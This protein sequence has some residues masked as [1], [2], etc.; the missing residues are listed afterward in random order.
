MNSAGQPPEI[1]DRHRRRAF[2]ERASVRNGDAFLWSLIAEELADRLSLVV[3][4]FQSVLII[5][6]IAMFQNVI[7]GPRDCRVTSALLGKPKTEVPGCYFM[8][9][10]HIPF[11]PS[12]F[13]LV[14]SAGTL[15]S[16]NDLPGALVQIRRILKPDGLFLGHMFGAGTLAGLKSM[17]LAAE[18]DRASSHIHPQIDLRNAADLL[19]RAGFALPVADQD[20][21]KV[22]YANWRTI[23][24]DI[25]DAGLGNALVGPRQFLGKAI[26]ARIDQQWET[27]LG[28][29]AKASESFVHL[30]MSGWAPSPDQPKPAKKGSGNI[31]L[32]AILPPPAKLP[33]NRS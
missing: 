19:T 4:D 23:V 6:P 21:L 16:V 22:H 25:R 2:Q 12:S 10:D 1:F 28:T 17:L 33:E 27:R 3:R 18:G 14:V 30:Y 11:D 24:G 32:A 20:M 29:A 26:L 31:S 8:E 7:L 15:D 13:D 9:E 5:G